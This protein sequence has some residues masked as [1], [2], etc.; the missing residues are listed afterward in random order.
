MCNKRPGNHVLT[1]NTSISSYKQVQIASDESRLVCLHDDDVKIVDIRS[2]EKIDQ[3]SAS[4][5]DEGLNEVV[6]CF[7]V[8]PSGDELVASTQNNLLR[9]WKFERDPTSNAIVSKDCVRAIRGHNMP[10]LAMTYDP[11]GTLIATGSADR[12]V[13]VW[14][15]ERGYCTH[16]FR[17]NT[18][19]VQNVI[20]HPDPQKLLLFSCSND[21][22]IRCFDLRDQKCISVMKDHISLPTGLAFSNDGYL[23]VSAG[24]DKVS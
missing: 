5:N 16:N 13:R 1:P 20:F 3:L 12:T 15:V 8:H 6:T 21:A 19:A 24:R 4:G 10:V 9:H 7:C 17:D 11:T 22:T 2:G 18:D 14:D 23:M